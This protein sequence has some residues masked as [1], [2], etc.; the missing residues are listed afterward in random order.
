MKANG[1][2]EPVLEAEVVEKT[3]PKPAKAKGSSFGAKLGW[4]LVIVLAA[5]IGGVYAAPDIRARLEAAG[6]IEPLPQTA[7]SAP[8][9][10]LS[11]LQAELDRHEEMLIQH[12]G[13]ISALSEAT[14]NGTMATEH[15]ESG[16]SPNPGAIAPAPDRPEM[17]ALREELA[18]LSETVK[19]RHSDEE[20]GPAPSV[21][22]ARLEASEAETAGLRDRLAAL[23][24]AL[25]A[26]EDAR[27]D[28]N[29]RGR[30]L[31]SLSR[32]EDR[33]QRGEAFGAELEAMNPD[34]SA[35]PAIDQSAL[36]AALEALR[37]RSAGVPSTD[38]LIAR[39]D[40]LSREIGIASDK[41]E[42]RFLAS[43]FT[44]RRTDAAASGDDAALRDAS[45]RLKAR[46]LAGAVA[47]LET[48]SPE[49]KK[50]ASVWISQAND[51]LAVDDAVG[52]LFRVV[53]DDRTG[54]GA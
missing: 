3:P 53:T 39:F 44:V 4:V 25:Q 34:F 42:G 21:L 18:A 7:T 28:T 33:V 43:L 45:E 9:V 38:A 13:L 48:L 35:L 5:F 23:E 19:A 12:E 47:A 51:R 20:K 49:A 40:P 2:S 15:T 30:L 46:D 14:S 31:L 27:L 6:L 26:V 16:E 22:A 1:D 10:D 52:K 24:S 29:P 11:P 50:A 36:G 37:E 8:M 17:T 41:A 54:G 32:L